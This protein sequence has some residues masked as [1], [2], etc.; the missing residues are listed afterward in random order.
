MPNYIKN[1]L[2]V[3]SKENEVFA[4]L[5]G[6]ESVM[7]F[8]KIIPM[9]ESL[10]LED[11][12]TGNEGM[13]YLYLRATSLSFQRSELKEIEARLKSRKQFDKAIELGKKYLMNIMNTGHKTWYGWA[14]ENWGTKWNALEPKI[15]SDTCIEF[16]TA[17]AG[18]VSMIEKLSTHFPDVTFEYKYS[19]EDTGCIAVMVRLKMAFLQWFIQRIKAA[20]HTNLLSI[21][22]RITQ[23][24]TVSKMETMFR[25]KTKNS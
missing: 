12:S 13:K 10:N 24:I 5:K 22:D 14:C 6:E 9:P 20:K 23:N 17:W 15:V 18:V 21:F 1:R 11:S 7:D 19:D 8:N 25:T 2:T 4:F 3:N 16:E